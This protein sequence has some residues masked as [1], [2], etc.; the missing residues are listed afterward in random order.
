MKNGSDL[1]VGGIPSELEQAKDDVSG[2]TREIDGVGELYAGPDRVAEIRYDGTVIEERGPTEKVGGQI[3]TA[4]GTFE[5]TGERESWDPDDPTLTVH[6]EDGRS[7][8][9]VLDPTEVKGGY[10]FELKGE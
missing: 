4:H 5:V 3:L 1:Q 10:R 6:L 7:F 8:P 2:Q 9:V